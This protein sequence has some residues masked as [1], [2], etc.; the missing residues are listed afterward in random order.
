MSDLKK[1]D[2]KKTIRK[3][4]RYI[5]RH[6]PL[7]VL[8]IILAAIIVFLTLYIPILI[9]NA[10]DVLLA[11]KG[12]ID[13]EE[14]IR[15]MIKIGI[16]MGITALAQWVMNTINNHITYH[17]VEDIRNDAMKKIQIL[18]L[19]FLDSQATGDVV[20]RVVSDVDTFADGLLMGFTQLFTGVLTILGTLGFM[21]RTSPIV[22]IV[23]VVITPLSFFVAKFIATHTHDYFKNQSVVRAEQTALIDEMIGNQKIVKMF[24]REEAVKEEFDEIN[25]RLHDSSLK[26]VF[27][28]SLVNPS[29]RFV[30]AL[31]YAGVAV[32]GGFF[33]IKGWGSAEAAALTVG[34]LTAFLSYANQYT[35]PFNEISGVITEL[36]NAIVCASRIFELIEKEPQIPDADSAKVLKEPEGAV[37]LQNVSFRYIP[38]KPLIRD[39]NLEVKPGQR[40]AIVGPTGCGKTTVIN[41]L[42][43]FYDVDEGKISIDGTDLRELTRKSLRSNIG[44]VLQETWLK[45]GTIKENICMGKPDATDEEIVAAAKAAHSHSFI[46]RLP[47]GYDTVIGEDGGMLSQGQKQLLCITRVMLCLPPMLILDEATSSIDTRTEIRIQKAFAKMMQGR[48]SFIVAHRLSTIKEADVILVMRDG[49]IVEQGN[50][51]SLLA[52]GGFYAELYNSQ[53]AI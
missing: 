49:N 39:F 22:T 6:I 35:K 12:N 48:T 4:L 13:F 24:S 15:I 9:G 47:D 7:V 16:V 21:L 53:F 40:I 8:S 20:S 30:N 10:V 18:P 52:K 36:Q 42:M 2:S 43:R 41:L 5:K 33:V 23:V 1:T 25:G 17:V 11:G 31:V 37:S 46:K 38:E 44:M 29:T 51:E 26:A 45:A 34:E 3:I 14:L 19:S 32:V 27:Y 28:S 50:H